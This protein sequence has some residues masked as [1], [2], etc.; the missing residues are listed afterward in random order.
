MTLQKTLQKKIKRRNDRVV[1]SIQHYLKDSENQA[2]VHDMRTSLRKLEVTYSLLPKKARRANSKYIEN[3][4]RFFRANS[5][6]RDLDVIRERIKEEGKQEVPRGLLQELEVIR[7]S[8]LGRSKK[9]VTLL[10]NPPRTIRKT[11]L[12]KSKV[13][14]RANKVAGRLLR[15]IRELL[16]V[17]LA[18]EQDAER[19]HDL[20]K[21]CK[22]FRYVL[23]TIGGGRYRKH[24]EANFAKLLSSR[25]K[26]ARD[27]DIGAVLKELQDIL[28]AIHDADITI[29]F[30]NSHSNSN[31]AAIKRLVFLEIQK[32]K[33][34]YERFVD[35]IVPSK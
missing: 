26:L 34:A 19:L 14:A 12:E 10:I 9:L 22:K 7:R 29:E 35:Y 18:D 4:K 23:E 28:G 16:P 6:I 17:V 30:I 8:E 11:Q 15:R 27:K 1:V 25:G 20:R 21:N 31:N 13:E 5:K 24:H 3:C 33:Q 2:T 32:R